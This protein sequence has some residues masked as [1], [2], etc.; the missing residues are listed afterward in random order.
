MIR[1]AV[2]VAVAM[3]VSPTCLWAQTV[4][5][6]KAASAEIYKSPSTGSPIIGQAPAGAVL[7]VTRELGSWVKVSWPDAQDG[8][9]YVHV[10]RGTLGHRS[11]SEPSQPTGSTSRPAPAP[12]SSAPAASRAQRPAVDERPA[13][14]RP[15]YV[16]PSTHLVGLGGRVGGPTFG[17][18]ATARMWTRNRVGAQLGMSRYVFTSIDPSQRA[19]TMQ[20]EPSLLYA[21]ADHVTDYLWVRPYVGSGF[22]FNRQTMSDA[23]PGAGASVSANASGLQVFGGGELTFASVPRFALSVDL[24]YRWIR[25]SFAGVDLGGVGV[26]VSGHWYVK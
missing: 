9:G 12:A 18:G 14:F 13:P 20:F 15:V 6:V 25:T 19:T 21:P 17:I 11:A 8:V 3:C 5:T 10:S 2:A 4:L 23:Q 7:D 1:H 24:A 26:S 22:T 16:T